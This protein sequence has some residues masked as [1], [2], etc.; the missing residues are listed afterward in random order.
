M[1]LE[2]DLKYQM[3]SATA[4]ESISSVFAFASSCNAMLLDFQFFFS[5][6]FC[7]VILVL[8]EQL[9]SVTLTPLTMTFRKTLCPPVAV[10]IAAAACH[11]PNVVCPPMLCFVALHFRCQWICSH[12]FR[13]SL[14][15]ADTTE[16]HR[17]QCASACDGFVVWFRLPPNKSIWF[18]KLRSLAKRTHRLTD[19][20]KLKT[21]RHENERLKNE[22]GMYAFVLHAA[23]ATFRFHHSSVSLIR[24]QYLQNIFFCGFSVAVCRHCGRVVGEK[25][26]N[27]NKWIKWG[28]GRPVRISSVQ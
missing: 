3:D 7:V 19:A 4:F 13:V 14:G 24:I 22:I 2:C 12:E 10:A 5:L 17:F 26:I 1:R 9:Q 6:V 16:S 27:K 28:V 18:I 23:T 20:H 21:F 8:T 15:S 11:S 25:K